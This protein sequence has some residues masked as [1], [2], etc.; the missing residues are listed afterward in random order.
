VVRTAAVSRRPLIACSRKRPPQESH[1]RAQL[2][3]L[4]RGEKP[5]STSS[6][7][8]P[9]RSGAS[10]PATSVCRA[11]R[12]GALTFGSEVVARVVMGTVPCLLLATFASKNACEDQMRS[13]R[14]APHG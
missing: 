1:G 13:W 9:P 11:G 12:P 4:R 14:G 8:V 7:K 5:G 10:P 2:A 6:S 3:Q